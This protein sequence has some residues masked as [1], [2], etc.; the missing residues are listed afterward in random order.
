M[1]RTVPT[2]SLIALSAG[3]GVAGL[4]AMEPAAVPTPVIKPTV[5]AGEQSIAL[6]TPDLANVAKGRFFLSADQGK[7]WILAQEIAVDPAT[8]KPPVFIFK[9][10]ADGAYYIV[11]ATVAKNGAA[12]PAP[13][14]GSIPGK[15]LFLVVDSTPPVVTSLT[16][17]P[18]PIS[19]PAATTAEV[20]VTWAVSDANLTGAELESSLD[21]GSS[22]TTAQVIAASGSAKLTFPLVKDHDLLLRIKAKDAAGNQTTS[23]AT[24]VALP[25]PPDP[26]KVLDEAVKSLPTLAEI[27]PP[28]EPVVPVPAAVSDTAA[29]APAAT[30]TTTPAT[31]TTAGTPAIAEAPA[32]TATPTTPPSVAPPVVAATTSRAVDAPTGTRFLTGAAA[33][34]QLAKAR[35]LRDALDLDNAHDVYLR[36]QNSSVAKTAVAEDL[37]LLYAAAD[38]AAVV[39]ISDNLRPELRSDTVRLVQGKSLLAVGRAAEAEQTLLKVSKGREESREALLYIGKAAFAQGKVALSTK[40]YEKLAQGEDAVA[41][42]AKLLRGK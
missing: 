28:P 11:T 41:A 26:V 39:A 33:D 18:T 2:A 42:E 38:H 35:S 13:A 24:S 27:Q 32:T 17:V 15:S 30:T 10:A 9:P 14:N 34:E 21:G 3:L 22:Y 20:V 7:N 23:P 19:D 5:V 25:V 37:N 12:E 6:D 31:T 1:R 16:A 8:K 40:I 4:G 36:L 29:T